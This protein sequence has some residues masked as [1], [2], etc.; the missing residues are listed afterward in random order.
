MAT[1][2]RLGSALRPR[3][4]FDLVAAPLLFLALIVAVWKLALA[5]EWVGAGR[6]PTLPVPP[7]DFEQFGELVGGELGDAREDGA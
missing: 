2:S 4:L 6:G 7:D 1:A 3:R 5:Q